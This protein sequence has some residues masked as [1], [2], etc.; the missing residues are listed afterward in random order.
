[1]EAYYWKGFIGVFIGAIF[2]Y[3]ATYIID[4]NIYK[5]NKTFTN[6]TFTAFA[7]TCVLYFVASQSSALLAPFL[8]FILLYYGLTKQLHEIIT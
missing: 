1:M 2:N 3:L 4:K 7:A 8:A 6:A 5:R